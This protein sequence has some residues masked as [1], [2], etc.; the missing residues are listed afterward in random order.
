MAIGKYLSVTTSCH[1]KGPKIG[2][3]LGGGEAGDEYQMARISKLV[4][5]MAGSITSEPRMLASTR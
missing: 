3:G 5:A 2:D 4:P 1:G